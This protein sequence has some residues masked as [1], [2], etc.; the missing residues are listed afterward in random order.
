MKRW[1]QSG[2]FTGMEKIEVNDLGISRLQPGSR[3]NRVLN[4]DLPLHAWLKFIWDLG[5]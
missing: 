1:D 2:I 4:I 5:S 3:V